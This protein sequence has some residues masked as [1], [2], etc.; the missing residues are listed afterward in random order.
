M[1]IAAMVFGVA[2]AYSKELGLDLATFKTRR[3]AWFLI[4]AAAFL[5]HNFWV[6]SCI[7][8]ITLMNANKSEKNTLSLVFFVMFAVPLFGDNITGLGIINYLFELNYFRI[9]SIVLLLP[10]YIQL[11]AKKSTVSFGA[12]WADKFLLV[13]LFYQIILIFPN[14]SLTNILRIIFTNFIEVFLPY[15][16]ASRYIKNQQDFSDVFKAYILGALVAGL[17]GVFEYLKGW[18]LYSTLQEALGAENWGYGGYLTRGVDLRALGS[19]GQPIVLGYIMAIALGAFLWIK[20]SIQSLN[21][22][23]MILLG[24]LASLFAPLSRGPWTGAVVVV[25]IYYSFQTG[26]L[27]QASRVLIVAVAGFSAVL[28]SPLGDQILEM[29]PGSENVDKKNINFR[30]DL[31][32]NALAVISRNPIFGSSDYLETEEMGAMRNGGDKS[33][34][35]VVNSY[36]AIALSGGLVGLFLFCGIFISCLIVVLKG[37]LKEG[38]GLLDRKLLMSLFSIMCGIVVMIYTV[39]SITYIPIIYWLFCGLCVAATQSYSKK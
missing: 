5:S 26:K 30:Q 19:S 6:F 38:G 15:Y 11:R 25:L 34:I 28:A 10:L 37:I 4:S 2:Q 39:S 7:A 20:D 12:Y 36:L 13:Y 32:T 29:L 16:V 1:A 33:I 8:V 21:L 3:N 23:W 14:T 9:I 17:I 27:A 35:D 18:L 22:R 31:L 24:L